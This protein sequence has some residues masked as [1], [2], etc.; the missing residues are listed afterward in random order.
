MASLNCMVPSPAGVEKRNS[1]KKLKIAMFSN[2]FPPL[3][4][5]SA[6]QS[7]ALAREL[8]KQGHEVVVFTARVKAD[9]PAHEVIGQGVEVYRVPC[10]KLP[11]MPI[12]MN[13]EWIN[14]TFLPKN[15][16]FI[17][18]K[19]KEKQVQ[20]IH[21]HNHMFDMALIGMLLS[22]RLGIPA[23]VTVHT[24]IHHSKKI[25]NTVLHPL[26][27]HFLG[28]FVMRK[29]DAVICPDCTIDKYVNGR[30]GI[31]DGV[32]IPYGLSM[33]DDYSDEDVRQFKKKL[34]LDGKRVIVSLGHMHALRNRIA[35]VKSLPGLI[36][37]H[38]DV[39]LVIVG[40]RGYPQTEELVRELGLEKH[41]MFTG[42]QPH[43]VIPLFH[44]MAYCEAAWF[45][46]EFMA[47][48]GLACLEGMY[49]GKPVIVSCPEDTHEENGLKNYGNIIILP[50][51]PKAGQAFEALDFLLNDKSRSSEIGNNASS[52]V[53]S[54]FSWESVTAKHVGLYSNMLNEE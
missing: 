1:D 17:R 49:F 14:V 2:L 10:L 36:K 37:R 40:L 20:V 11:K 15:I 46:Q 44:R 39:R 18:Q 27:R 50:N 6:V 23:C 8:G 33:Q 35:L 38:P 45:D 53:K 48:V 31:N 13:F 9:S 51:C 43:E 26:D 24:V 32:V 25:Y 7:N 29:A 21:I 22:R 12:S 54:Y 5:G 41:V 4:T 19:L 16:S 34:G 47:P 52:F 3:S 28:R 42:P 30:F